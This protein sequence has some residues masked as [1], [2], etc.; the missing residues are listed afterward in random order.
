MVAQDGGVRNAEDNGF[1]IQVQD[2]RLP[3]LLVNI[4][5]LQTQYLME[6]I[7]GIVTN[8]IEDGEKYTF[9]NHPEREDP[10]VQHVD[11]VDLFHVE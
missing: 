10:I 8:V 6:K 7:H 3:L 11:V 4:V 5:N 2:L 1:G 9:Q